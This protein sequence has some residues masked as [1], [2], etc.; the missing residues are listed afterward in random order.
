MASWT[1]LVRFTAAEDGEAYYTTSD[2]NLPALGDKVATVKSIAALTTEGAVGDLKTVKEVG[3][4]Q[5]RL[6]CC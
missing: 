3:S 6:N 5:H 2:S 4:Q 1:H